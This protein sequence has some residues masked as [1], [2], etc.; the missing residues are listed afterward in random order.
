VDEMRKIFFRFFSRFIRGI[1]GAWKDLDFL[2]A[3]ANRRFQIW[4]ENVILPLAKIFWWVR[5]AW[6]SSD[7]ERG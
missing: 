5:L 1:F 3:Q 4:Q 6:I 7:A 2:V